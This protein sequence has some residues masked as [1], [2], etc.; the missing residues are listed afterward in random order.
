[1]GEESPHPIAINITDAEAKREV[2]LTLTVGQVQLIH[3]F[4]AQNIQLKGYDMVKF[5][6]DLFER[7][8]RALEESLE[9]NESNPTD[10]GF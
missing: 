9:S 7:L 4:L 6:Y 8:E 5:S 2:D 10:I 1:M 3:S